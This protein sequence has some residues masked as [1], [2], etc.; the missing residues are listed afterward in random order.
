MTAF[1]LSIISGIVATACWLFI[2]TVFQGL[3]L[4]WYRSQRYEGVMIEGEWVGWYANYSP[5]ST[6]ADSCTS[7][8][9]CKITLRQSATLITGELIELEGP[10]R[11]KRYDL[12]GDFRDLILNLKYR[13]SNRS[14]LDRGAIVL[15]LRENA[16][17]LEGHTLY[18]S[19]TGNGIKCLAYRWVR[20]N[21]ELPNIN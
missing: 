14:R 11:G 18:Y 21:S 20:I 9:K 2:N 16:Q 3:F 1:I 5:A 7:P 17:S 8:Q 6:T 4:P 15:C 12:V 13:E 10:D 19:D